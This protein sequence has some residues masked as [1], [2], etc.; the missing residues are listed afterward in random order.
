MGLAVGA[1][2]KVAAETCHTRLL[3]SPFVQP[4][5]KEEQGTC[6]VFAET[7][8]GARSHSFSKAILGASISASLALWLTL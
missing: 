3:A 6:W 5:P 8:A 7:G 1:K 2:T 4:K